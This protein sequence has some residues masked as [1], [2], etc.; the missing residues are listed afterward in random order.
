VCLRVGCMGFF[1]FTGVVLRGS[2]SMRVQR[3]KKR[4]SYDTKSALRLLFREDVWDA[5]N[6]L[7]V[8]GGPF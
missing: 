2:A 6:V 8:R 1:G 3:K 7:M 5:P 4:G